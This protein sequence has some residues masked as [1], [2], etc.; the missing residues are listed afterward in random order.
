MKEVV[1]GAPIKCTCHGVSGSCSFKTCYSELPEF[2]T[3]VSKLKEV[4]SEACEV[5][6]NGATQHRWISQCGRDFQESDFI[7]RSTFNW[8]RFNPSVGSLGVIGRECDPN[9]TGPN[10][11]ENLCRGCGRGVERREEI[12]KRECDCTFLFCCE[13]KCKECEVHRAYYVCT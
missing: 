3:I 2:S 12:L 5:S 11:C 1:V 13:I 4:Y 10:S 7:Y 9:S 6:S 8:C